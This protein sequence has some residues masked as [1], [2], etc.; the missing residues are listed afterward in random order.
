MLP[1]EITHEAS[2]IVSYDEATSTEAL[3]NDVNVLDKARDVA[4]ARATQYQQNLRNYHSSRVRPRSSMVGDLVLRLKQDGHRKLESP[5][6]GPYIVTE[7]IPG[8]AYRLQDKKTGKDE[9]NPWNAEQLRRF[10]A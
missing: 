3:Q 2:W 1:V 5:W 10:Y 8:G 9:S 4:L 7:V 6:V